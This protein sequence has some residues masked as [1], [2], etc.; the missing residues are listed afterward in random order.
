MSDGDTPGGSEGEGDPSAISR[1]VDPFHQP[2]SNEAIDE[3]TR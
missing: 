3:S 2:G 1:I